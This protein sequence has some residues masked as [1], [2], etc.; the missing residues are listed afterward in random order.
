MSDRNSASLIVKLEGEHAINVNT[1]I[2][3][4]H[5]SWVRELKPDNDYPDYRPIKNIKV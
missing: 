4:S 2:M 1:S 5:H 3:Q